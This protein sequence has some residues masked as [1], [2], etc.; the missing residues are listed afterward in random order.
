MPLTLTLHPEKTRIVNL[1]DGKEG[2]DFLGMHNRNMATHTMDGR[3]YYTLH[4]FPSRKAMKKCA[5]QLTGID[6]RY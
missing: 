4:Q 1:W 6:F 5:D 3:K 2:F